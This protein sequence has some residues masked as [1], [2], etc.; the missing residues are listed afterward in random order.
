M[1]GE[2]PVAAAPAPPVA[3]ATVATGTKAVVGNTIAPLTPT[4]AKNTTA[5]VPNYYNWW[6]I[7]DLESEKAPAKDSTP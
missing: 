3:A 1:V 5:A 7:P 2:L 4:V 6:E